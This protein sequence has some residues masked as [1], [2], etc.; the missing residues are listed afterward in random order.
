MA[1]RADEAARAGLTNVL[2]Y[3]IPRA[4]DLDQD[5]RARSREALLDIADRLGPVVD[6]YP[7]WHPLVRNYKND[8]Y[9]TMRPSEECGYR[10][11]DH[12]RYFANG[13]IT[14]PYGDGQEVLDSV[15]SLPSHPAAQITAERLDVKLYNSSCTPILV[16]C[17]WEKSLSPD[18][19]IPLSIAMPLLLEKELPC[20]WRAQV[21]ETWESMR[22]YFLGRPY[23]SRSSLFINQ[24]TGQAIKKI[25]VALIYTGMFGPIKV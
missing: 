21:G 19:T 16:E 17:E 3:L 25:W 10:G 8:R 1:F 14:C 20:V 12:T 11:L 15:A 23:G 13:F 22:P 6:A 18:G 9:P 5:E 2:D 7:S 24:E 4:Q